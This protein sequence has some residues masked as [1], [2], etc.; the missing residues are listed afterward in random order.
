MVGLTKLADD[1]GYL[2]MNEDGDILEA[3]YVYMN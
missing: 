2:V 3:S 1:L